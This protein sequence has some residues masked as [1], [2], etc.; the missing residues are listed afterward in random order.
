MSIRQVAER[1]PVSKNTVQSLL[2]R[3]QATG[4]LK[5]AQATGG[6]A[7]QLTGYE[8]EIAEMVETHQD[9]TLSEYCEYWLSPHSPEFNPIEHLWWQLKALIRR[10]VPKSVKAITQLLEL[11]VRLCSSRELRNYFA[12]CYYCTN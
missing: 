12:H 6:K 10:F 7:S 9:Y 1:F 11:G 4:A 2:K 3:K 8:Q 5:P